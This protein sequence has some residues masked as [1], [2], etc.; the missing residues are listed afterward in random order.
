[1]NTLLMD[2]DGNIIDLL[3]GKLDIY[4]KIIT[5]VKE[6]NTLFMEDKT[7][8]LRAIRFMTTLNMQLDASI[9]NYII[10]NKEVFTKISNT[11]IKSELDKIFKSKRSGKFISFIKQ[12]NL[13]E[14]IGIIP[15]NKFKST[16][17]LVSSYAELK[18][19]R[20]L[21]FTKYEKESISKIKKLIEKGSLTKWD[22]YKN[23]LY[24]STCAS[25][26]LGISKKEINLIYTNLPINSIIDIDLKPEEICSYLNIEPIYLLGKILHNLEYDII[27]NNVPNKKEILLERISDYIN[28]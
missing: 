5:P 26:V 18:I 19:T 27:M 25:E 22:I 3:G 8:V 10:N 9:L 15:I 17:T 21:P 28:E 14:Y 20:N 2:K 6:V 23:G 13:E 1:M 7:R 4:N 12:Y 11:K 16:H 24:I